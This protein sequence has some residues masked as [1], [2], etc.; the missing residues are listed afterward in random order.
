MRM[1]SHYQRTGRSGFPPAAEPGF[2]L[3]ELLV[4]I[5]IIALLI[6]ILLPALGSARDTARTITCLSNMRQ[7][8]LASAL[9]TDEHRTFIDAAFPDEG[10]APP[11]DIENAWPV[12][13]T[14]YLGASGA[15]RSPADSSTAWSVADGGDSPGLGRAEALLRLAN[16]DPADNPAQ[17]DLARWTSY[18]LTDFTT[19]KLGAVPPIK[20]LGQIRPARAPKD[21]PFPATTVHF[22]IMTFDGLG[23]DSTR[24]TGFVKSDH[25]HPITWAPSP[26]RPRPAHIAAAE[27]META[28]HGGDESTDTALSN[29]S[30]F[31]GSARTLR[32]NEI[33]TDI[34]TNKLI[35]QIAR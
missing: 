2:T 29:Y 9:Y 8:E 30:F 22:L 5:A 11:E 16:D 26:F 18:G 35:P 12:T 1:H 14:N 27:Q 7:L 4:V 19:T 17:G 32:F 24:P 31:D 3:I 34:T 15:F 13:L 10:D 25:V 28:A 21:I 33:F 20:G 6:G 23:P